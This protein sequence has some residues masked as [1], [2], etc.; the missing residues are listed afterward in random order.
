MTA[1]PFD[2]LKLS[3]QLRERAHLNSRAGGSANYGEVTFR[4]QFGGSLPSSFLESDKTGLS[5]MLRSEAVMQPIDLI[6][7]IRNRRG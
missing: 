2:T 1:A 4:F 5:N 6:F 7:S 3:R